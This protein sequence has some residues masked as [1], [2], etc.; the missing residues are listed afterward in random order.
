MRR[1]AA[2]FRRATPTR[3]HG[4]RARQDYG[5]ATL[6]VNIRDEVPPLSCSCAYFRP[7]WLAPARA[8]TFI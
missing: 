2:S 7:F 1:F 8:L 3:R 6:G 4:V 5:R